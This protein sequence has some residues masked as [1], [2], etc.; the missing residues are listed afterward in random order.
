M[1]TPRLMLFSSKLVV[2][3]GAHLSRPVLSCPVLSICLTAPHRT[4][5]ALVQGEEEHQEG[6]TE[7]H[8][9]ASRSLLQT[10]FVAENFFDI[11]GGGRVAAG[12]SAFDRYT[13]QMD[14][15]PGRDPDDP[16]R[17]P[18]AFDVSLF[19]SHVLLVQV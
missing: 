6:I 12:F 7:N 11:A 5:Q 2:C 1:F 4:A 18:D 19:V 13:A 8:G 15:V 3:L 10:K 17:S 9:P 16:M 14:R